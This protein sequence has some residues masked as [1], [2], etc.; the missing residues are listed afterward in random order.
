MALLA[1][2]WMQ[3]RPLHGVMA[4]GPDG[5][6]VT[7]AGRAHELSAEIQPLQMRARSTVG[8]GDLGYVVHILRPDLWAIFHAH[9][10]TWKGVLLTPLG[11]LLQRVNLPQFPVSLT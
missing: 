4:L 6:T 9:L 1:A 10:S 8:R 11:S 3:Q 2:L 7:Q 5:R